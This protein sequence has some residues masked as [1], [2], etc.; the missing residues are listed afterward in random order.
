MTNITSSGFIENLYLKSKND[1]LIYY[2]NHEMFENYIK[3]VKLNENNVKVWSQKKCDNW[4]VGN[5]KRVIIF[6]DGLKVLE[7]LRIEIMSIIKDKNKRF[8][9][10]NGFIHKAKLDIHFKITK[11]IRSSDFMSKESLSMAFPQYSKNIINNRRKRKN[12]FKN[13]T[14][15]TSNKKNICIYE[16]VMS[17]FS[18]FKQI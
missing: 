16:N 1:I 3:G 8:K 11:V 2:K 13:S 9:W 10:R 14:I 4:I 7:E 18:I 6:G 5:K 15:T 17:A 12:S